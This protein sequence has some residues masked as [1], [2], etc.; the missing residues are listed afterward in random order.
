MPS[1]LSAVAHARDGICIRL[2][3]ALCRLGRVPSEFRSGKNE[4][5]FAAVGKELAVFREDRFQGE[6]KGV[7]LA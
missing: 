6:R 7:A 3:G 2:R 5:D 1:K 4:L